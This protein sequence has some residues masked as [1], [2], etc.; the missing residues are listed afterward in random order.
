MSIYYSNVREDV[1]RLIPER[2]FARVLEVGGGDF[3]TLLEVGRRSGAELWGADIRPVEIDGVTMVQG[4][5]DD[6]S[7]RAQLPSSS[8]DLVIANDVIEHLVDSEGFL[9]TVHDKLKPGGLL[10]LSVPNI[11]QL[12]SLY[13][14]FVRGTFARQD[15]GLFD[16]THVRWFCRGDVLTLARGAGLELLRWEGNGRFLPNLLRSTPAA[17]F[18]ALQNLFL[19]RR[20]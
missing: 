12:R 3:P 14:I 4:S 7:V 17:E 5:F 15:A 18:L 9:A 6:P 2:P 1:L 11:R 16:R 19:F 13:Y 20:P 8:F 10:A